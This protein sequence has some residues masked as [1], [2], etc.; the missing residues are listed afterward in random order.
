M[1]PSATVRLTGA[2]S[3]STTI[4]SLVIFLDCGGAISWSVKT[5]KCVALSSTEAKLNAI[6]EATCQAL[7]VHKYLPILRVNIQQLLSLFNNNQSAL[8]IVNTSSGTY[9]SRMKHYNI[10]LVH[11]CDMTACRHIC[12][13]YC[14]TDDVS[15]NVLTKVLK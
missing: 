4:Q 15:A 8:A 1:C 9:H 13:A 6:S 10:K 14:L 5:Q 2:T 7:Y 3:R 12:Y 11:L